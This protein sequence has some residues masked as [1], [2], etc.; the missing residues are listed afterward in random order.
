MS[1]KYVKSSN[2]KLQ[3]IIVM[4]MFLQ[5]TSSR[6]IQECMMQT[7][8]DKCLLYSTMKK[9]C[10]NFHHE[11]LATQDVAWYQIPKLLIMFMIL[12]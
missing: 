2:V 8:S 6:E 11:D 5:N 9:W 7:L 1:T 4:F 12:F 10:T 3:A